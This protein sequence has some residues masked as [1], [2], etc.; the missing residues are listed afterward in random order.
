MNNTIEAVL[1]SHPSEH[2][3]LT[4]PLII[5]RFF[6]N[7]IAQRKAGVYDGTPME[8][9]SCIELMKYELSAFNATLVSTYTTIM[10]DTP[11]DKLL[12]VMMWG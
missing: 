9:K 5:K 4:W 11:E 12:F 3:T 8:G 10:F 2:G 6:S 1:S 7:I